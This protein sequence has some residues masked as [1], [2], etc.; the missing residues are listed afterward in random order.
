M[1]P[2]ITAK[3]KHLEFALLN[4]NQA[5]ALSGSLQGSGNPAF[6]PTQHREGVFTAPRWINCFA[7]AVAR[8]P[9]IIPDPVPP[10]DSVLADRA[11]QRAPQ[12]TDGEGRSAQ[13][14]RRPQPPGTSS[15]TP[16]AFAS[17]PLLNFR[18][19]TG[20]QTPQSSLF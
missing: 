6:L 10:G 19:H 12:G 4:R 3:Y 7:E 16:G 11:S 20:A 17:R 13:P 2:I 8:R 9:Q 1:F 18:L 15:E 14:G 5:A